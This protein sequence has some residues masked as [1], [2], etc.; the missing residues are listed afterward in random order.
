MGNVNRQEVIFFT[1][2]SRNGRGMSYNMIETAG[3][4]KRRLMAAVAE[5]R[6]K[7][8]RIIH[9]AD[10]HLDSKM[11]ANLGR[12][13]AKERKAEILATFGRMAGYAENNGIEAILI[14]GDLFDARVTGV[15]VRSTVCDIIRSHE[16]IDFYYLKGNHDSCG[17]IETLD[18]IP[19]NLH[20]FDTSWTSYN[21]RDNVVLTGAEMPDRASFDAPTKVNA[22]WNSLVLDP[23]KLNIVMLHGQDGVSTGRDY[24]EIINLKELSGRGIDYLA[25]GHVHKYKRATLDARGIYC[26]CGALEGR[27]FDECGEHGF[28]VLDIDEKARR[29]TDTFVPFAWRRLHTVT[30]DVG[31]TAD[32][33]ELVS[34]AAEAIDEAG[35]EDCDLIKL[36]LTGEAEAERGVDAGYIAKRLEGNYYYLKVCDETH[37]VVQAGDYSL[38]KSL[39]GEFV[40][41]V[42][43]DDTLSEEDKAGIIAMGLKAILGEEM[44]Y[45][46]D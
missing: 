32:T 10:L 46:A 26:Y 42:M 4:G 16:S 44:L 18:E 38:D 5:S 37:P 28:V 11:T 36:A 45:E 17:F 29:I 15:R 34:M 33:E 25:L 41:T 40:R 2:V 22:L 39:K 31:S 14:A 3:G 30:V 43:A 20:T 19:H 12:D 35:A 7:S 6:E 21:L 13:K 1:A 23:D 24:T 27:G 8:V 9:C